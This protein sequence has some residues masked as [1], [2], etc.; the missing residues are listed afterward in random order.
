MTPGRPGPESGGDFVTEEQLEVAR[1]GAVQQASSRGKGRPLRTFLCDKIAP[2][3][4]A[5]SRPPSTHLWLRTVRQQ[6][7]IDDAAEAFAGRSKTK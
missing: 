3:F 1:N 4:W 7:I 5:C 2:R 6:N